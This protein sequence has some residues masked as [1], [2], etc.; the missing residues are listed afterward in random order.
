MLNIPPPHSTT[1]FTNPHTHDQSITTLLER[2]LFAHA[3]GGVPFPGFHERRRHG[4]LVYGANARINN[5]S[6]KYPNTH[7]HDS[8]IIIIIIRSFTAPHFGLGMA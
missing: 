5:N 8:I 1:H 6:H 7:A 3:L 4:N 2:L